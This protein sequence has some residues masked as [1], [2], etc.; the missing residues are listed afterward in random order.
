VKQP[1]YIDDDEPNWPII[2]LAFFVLFLVIAGATITLIHAVFLPILEA[3]TPT[4]GVYAA[5]SITS[6]LWML[7]GFLIVFSLG[8]VFQRLKSKADSSS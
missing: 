8:I 4:L 6:V 2:I 7:A 1:T 5:A 3:L